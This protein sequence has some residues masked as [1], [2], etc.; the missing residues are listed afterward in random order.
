MSSSAFSRRPSSQTGWRRGGG[1]V[2]AGRKETP[3][4]RAQS[5]A[6]GEV[7]MELKPDD[8]KDVKKNSKIKDCKYVA[9]YNWLDGK[10][11]KIAVPGK[12][13]LAPYH[14]ACHPRSVS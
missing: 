10:D 8:I 12:L 6:R 13:I 9:S 4:F 3:N 14:F 5:P 11:P 7:L 2:S 1:V